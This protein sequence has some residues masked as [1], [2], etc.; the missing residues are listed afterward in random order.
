MKHRIKVTGDYIDNEAIYDIH[1]DKSQLLCRFEP[2][3]LSDSVHKHFSSCTEGITRNQSRDEISSENKLPPS[4]ELLRTQ[5][6]PEDRDDLWENGSKVRLAIHECWNK[7]WAS[8]TRRNMLLRFAKNPVTT[9]H[10]WLTKPGSDSHQAFLE[11]YELADSRNDF[12]AQPW[13]K[14]AVKTYMEK[15]KK[16]FEELIKQT[17]QVS[18]PQQWATTLHHMGA[19]NLERS[20]VLQSQNNLESEDVQKLLDSNVRIPVFTQVNRQTQADRYMNSNIM[21]RFD[22]YLSQYNSYV[23]QACSMPLNH[24]NSFS[25]YHGPQGFPGNFPTVAFPVTN[26]TTYMSSPHEMILNQFN[27]SNLHVDSIPHTTNNPSSI[28]R[29]PNQPQATPLTVSRPLF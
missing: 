3:S 12:Y 19:N 28:G 14:S 27:P 7:V 29:S 5:F 8:I 24:F 10:L 1:V 22:Q 13:V 20:N 18:D 15:H 23:N 21:N 25:I 16:S 26:P 11:E 2:F 4:I 17:L 9:M 6:N